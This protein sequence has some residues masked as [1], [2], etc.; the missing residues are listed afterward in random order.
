MTKHIRDGPGTQSKQLHEESHHPIIEIVKHTISPLSV[1][2]FIWFAGKQNLMPNYRAYYRAKE[3][4]RA[5]RHRATQTTNSDGSRLFDA[6]ATATS[7]FR[8]YSTSARSPLLGVSV[9]TPFI[10]VQE[11]SPKPSF[12]QSRMFAGV[13]RQCVSVTPK[14]F[15]SS[16]KIN[17]PSFRSGSPL[18]FSTN[19]VLL[20]SRFR[21]TS[22]AAN[23]RGLSVSA[24]L[25]S[26]V[27]I[28]PATSI[29][30]QS[31][32]DSLVQIAAATPAEP[33]PFHNVERLA[34]V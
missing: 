24:T 2:L 5:A 9:R 4:I 14:I 7:Q 23:V 26:S 11:F 33:L 10:A 22:F 20:S 34:G 27:P 32:L 28:E 31:P 18:L 25:C 30:T 17:F 21:L 29:A 19:G 16:P 12:Q 15:Q 13:P 3:V 8:S 6:K 1:A